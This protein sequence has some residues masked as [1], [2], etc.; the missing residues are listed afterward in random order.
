MSMSGWWFAASAS[1]ATRVTNAIAS[2]NDASSYVRTMAS[3]DRSHPGRR[4]RPASTSGLGS[5][6]IGGAAR[7][8]G[9]ELRVALLQ[10]GLE[11]PIGG[12]PQLAARALVDLGHERHPMPWPRTASRRSVVSTAAGVAG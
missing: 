7:A 4:A 9:L 10:V 8:L 2:G 6:A 3:P 11:L 1:S 5:V 12:E